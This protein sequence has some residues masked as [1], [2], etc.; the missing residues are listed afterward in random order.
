MIPNNK[1]AEVARASL[2][3]K[4]MFYVLS[5]RQRNRKSLTLTR[6]RTDI[7]AALNTELSLND[8]HKTLQALEALG[9]GTIQYGSRGGA[10]VF[11]WAISMRD[12][13]RMAGVTERE[14]K[15]ANPVTGVGK[16]VMITNL[17]RIVNGKRINA[18]L[19]AKQATTADLTNHVVFVFP[20]GSI[21]KVDFS[22]SLPDSTLVDL[23]KVFLKG[24]GAKKIELTNELESTGSGES[25][26]GTKRSQLS[27]VSNQ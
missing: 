14:F 21:K 13:V 17:P 3:S 1:F 26:D 16:P 9:V 18:S 7:R 24:V 19:I 8:F 23:A 11:T 5:Q 15:E 2:T 4:A 20:D 10:K 12:V 22:D 27:N 6:L 25:A